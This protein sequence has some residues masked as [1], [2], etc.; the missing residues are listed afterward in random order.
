MHSHPHP[1]HHHNDSIGWHDRNPLRRQQERRRALTTTTAPKKY[2][3]TLCVI[4]RNE[5]NILVEFM[6]HHLEQGVEHFYI[7]D[8]S[9]TDSFQARL[10]ACSISSS[11]YSIYQRSFGPGGTYRSQVEVCARGTDE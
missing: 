7:V 3:L 10:E 1:H 5:G 8:D 4:I 9:S 6:Q 11:Q 2:F